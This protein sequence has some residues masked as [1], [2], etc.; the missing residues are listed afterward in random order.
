MKKTIPLLSIILF[1]YQVSVGQRLSGAEIYYSKLSK[2]TYKATAVVYREC[3]FDALQSINGLVINDSFSQSLSFTRVS[4]STV[5]A[6]C[7]NPCNIQNS[8]SNKGMEKHVFEATLDLTL[9][10]YTKFISPNYC[11]IRIAIRQGGRDNRTTTH[12]SGMFYVDAEVNICDTTT[13]SNTSP[14]FG[15]EPKFRVPINFPVYYSP[16]AMDSIELDSLVYALAPVE[17]N[18]KTSIAYNGS[19]TYLYPFNAYCPPNNNGP[20]RSLQNS[21]P[22]RGFSFDNTTGQMTYMPTGTGMGYINIK[23][24]EYKKVG[25]TMVYQ[26]YI[27]REMLIENVIAG[28][29]APEFVNQTSSNTLNICSDTGLFIIGSYDNPNPKTMKIDTGI[30]ELAGPL[31]YNLLNDFSK[32]YTSAIVNIPY[33]G[34]GIG[35]TRQFTMKVMDSY[36]NESFNTKTFQIITHE[37]FDYTVNHLQDSCGNIQFT[38]TR[39]DVN[40]AVY[41]STIS[42]SKDAIQEPNVINS[43]QFSKPGNHLFKHEYR[44]ASSFCIN[45]KQEIIQSLGDMPDVRFNIIKDTTICKGSPS[46]LKFNPYLYNRNISWK[47]FRNDTLINSSDSILTEPVNNNCTYK[48]TVFEGDCSRSGIRKIKVFNTFVSSILAKDS[49]TFCPNTPA[50]ITIKNILYNQQNHIV[51]DGLD[52]T[53]TD[54]TFRFVARTKVRSTLK[55]EISDGT[56]CKYYDTMMIHYY[57]LINGPQLGIKQTSLCEGDTVEATPIITSDFDDKSIEWYIDGYK[58]TA[59]SNNVIKFPLIKK[60]EIELKVKDKNTC[61]YSHIDTLNPFAKMSIEKLNIQNECVGKP[62]QVGFTLKGNNYPRKFQW[63]IDDQYVSNDSILN[64]IS[65]AKIKIKLIV[66]YGDNC[67][68]S[69]GGSYKFNAPTPFEIAGSKEFSSIESVYLYSPANFKSYLWSNGHTGRYLTIKAS[70]LGPP[71][72]YTFWL[73]IENFTSCYSFDT[74]EISTEKPVGINALNQDE[75]KVYPNPSNGDVLHIFSTRQS[76]CKIYTSEGVW[77]MSNEVKPGD[78]EYQLKDLNSGIYYLEIEGNYLKFVI[79]KTY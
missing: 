63:Y 44:I 2:Y 58:L 79:N 32:T 50:E 53:T 12:S 36:C 78:N 18:Y 14:K 3:E 48:L 4:I 74:V 77:V 62:T 40:G 8:I 59:D 46:G 67:K 28:N 33:F 24:Y 72:K 34:N 61:S 57:P 42:N 10:G 9:S 70:D 35:N 56:L 45:T 49:M 17:T 71:G 5:N 7:G 47:W 27:S 65:K 11:K 25:Q 37:K 69:L 38:A 23:V 51:M 20:C 43:F 68:D 75:F 26:G 15:I 21:K 30:F 76:E 13:K 22:P 64:L 60:T 52:T 39:K 6:K 41:G 16:G 73:R 19:L 29:P 31:S 1:Y 54:L 55:V 66:T